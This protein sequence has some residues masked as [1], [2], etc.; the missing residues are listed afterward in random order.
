MKYKRVLLKL[1]GQML[2][3]QGEG[4]SPEIA[5]ATVQEIKSV[6]ETGLEL[7]ILVGGGKLI[8]ARDM[9]RCATGTV[10]SNLE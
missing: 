8:R 10:P 4:F 2:G 7:A 1:S 5:L 3:R 9:Q 6:L